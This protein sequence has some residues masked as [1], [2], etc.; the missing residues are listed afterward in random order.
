MHVHHLLNNNSIANKFIAQLR[1]VNVQQDRMRFRRNI[2]RLGEILSYELSSKLQYTTKEI[3]SPLGTSKVEVPTNDIVICSILRAGLPL[4]NGILNYFDDAENSFISAYRHHPNDDD[5]FEIKVEY[6]ASPS[7]NGKTLILA[8]PM[9][10]T[11]RS[12]VN[13]MQ[14]L[15]QMGTPK[16]IHL[17]AIIGAE[18]GLKL[19]DD[20]FPQNTHLWIAA[21]DQKLDYRGYIVPG[22]GDAGDLCFGTKKQH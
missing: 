1:D 2:E 3:T 22:L 6:L 7:L 12:F 14:A 19:L 4:H 5:E 8:D 15:K 18:E 20:E 16:E 17:V 21:I 9:L 13:V 10:A 11:G